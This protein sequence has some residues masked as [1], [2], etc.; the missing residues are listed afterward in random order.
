[1]W[2]I[3]WNLIKIPEESFERLSCVCTIDRRESATSDNIMLADPR[4][5]GNG[6]QFAYKMFCS[7]AKNGSQAAPNKL[8]TSIV[9]SLNELGSKKWGEVCLMIAN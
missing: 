8:C 6:R 9:N 2:P 3:I 1:M 7:I 5:A 4:K